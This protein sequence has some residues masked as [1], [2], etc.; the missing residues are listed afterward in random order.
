MWTL[1]YV[2]AAIKK[3]AY[4]PGL[5]DVEPVNAYRRYQQNGRMP[6]ADVTALRGSCCR[7][8]SGPIFRAQRTTAKAC[9]VVDYLAALSEQEEEGR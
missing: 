2:H 6:D 4:L 1:I 7:L 8:G 3:V 9:A 5:L